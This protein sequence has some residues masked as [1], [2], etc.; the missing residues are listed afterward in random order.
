V[1]CSSAPAKS[2][3]LWPLRPIT[4]GPCAALRD[5]RAPAQCFLPPISLPIRFTTRRLAAGRPLSALCAAAACVACAPVLGAAGPH[6]RTNDSRAANFW[7]WKWRYFGYCAAPMGWLCSFFGAKRAP[8]SWGPF[9]RYWRV[10]SDP[11]GGCGTP[12]GS[13]D[14]WLC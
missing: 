11:H 8:P 14:P 5:A 12:R 7:R 1:R 2:N 6:L 13:G 9:V 3:R 4:T 10:T